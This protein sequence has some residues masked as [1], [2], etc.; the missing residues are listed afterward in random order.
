MSIPWELRESRLLFN[1][2]VGRI[3]FTFNGNTLGEELAFILEKI[4]NNEKRKLG[5]HTLDSHVVVWT[6]RNENPD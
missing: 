5:N 6:T 1:P 2:S 3:S 4:G